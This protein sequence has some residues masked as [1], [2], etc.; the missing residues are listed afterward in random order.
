LEVA[1]IAQS[2]W[3]CLHFSL[4]EEQII[5]NFKFGLKN[6]YTNFALTGADI[7]AYGVDIGT[8]LSNLLK[9]LFAIEGEYK[10][11]LIDLNA[12]W[13][14]KYCDNLVAILK[15][16]AK[17]LSRIM[18]PIQSGSNRI[19]RLMNRRYNIDDVKKCIL[20]LQKNVPSLNIETHILVGFPGET[21][22][23]FQMS[24]NLLKDI[25]FSKVE[26]YRYEDRPR[27]AASKMADKVSDK[28]KKKRAR[29]LAEIA[30]EAACVFY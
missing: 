14:V 10:L 4:P 15:K 13:L 18:I 5:E 30:N 7:G 22:E 28:T 11:N 17:K 9:K 8:S 20:A 21:E 29:R 24:L 1:L 26:I 12:R 3:R 27:T 6:N 23:D 16:N 2:N 19:L 25:Q